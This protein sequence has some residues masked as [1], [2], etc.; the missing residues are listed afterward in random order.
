MCA[1]RSYC[2]AAPQTRSLV[3]YT[4]TVLCLCGVLPRLSGEL[5]SIVVEKC[6]EIDVEIKLDE[7][8]NAK[9]HLTQTQVCGG[10]FCGAVWCVADVVLCFS[11]TYATRAHVLPATPT[12]TGQQQWWVGEWCGVAE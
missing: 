11:L 9:L 8:G 5:M 4:R 10:V 6:L 1:A 12:V 7:N 3:A 2:V